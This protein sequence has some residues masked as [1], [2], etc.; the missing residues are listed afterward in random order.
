VN[1]KIS[2]VLAGIGLSTSGI[3][4]AADSVSVYGLID[5]G[6]TYYS[7]TSANK[8]M[9]RMDSGIAQSS[10][11]GFRGNEDL[12]GGNS[13]FFTLETGFSA[14]TGT[15]GQGGAIFGRQAVLGIR[16]QRLGTVSLG[17]QYDFMSNLGIAYAMGANSAA[18]SFAWG[19][20]ADAANQSILNNHIYVGDRTTNSIKYQTNDI[21]GFTG[22]LM[23]GLGEVAG[24][25]S[26]GRTVSG[27]A[28]YARGRFSTG[29]AFTHIRN[30]AD[31]GST[32]IGGFGASYVLD[33]VKV[34]GV[35]TVA[36]VT[37]TSA[38]AKTFEV[39]A[40]H[41]LTP[42][43]D[44]SG[45]W[46]YQDRNRAVSGA[47]ALVAVLDYKLSRRT[48]VYLGAVYANDNGYSA[49]PVYGGGLQ[50]AGGVQTALRVGLRHRF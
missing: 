29:A 25:A 5:L 35:A 20:H 28:S 23:Y 10:R 42:D 6:L 22:G 30:A 44:L 37:P 18:G 49:Y 24:N 16:N 26:A 7:S 12:G 40:T 47:Q 36:S 45:A 50:A 31:T 43:I 33:R 2:I 27:L 38:K 17:R 11:L 3:A 1:H 14:D 34:W 46:Q 9:I 41:A 4:Q 21:D 32:R 19:L 15:L 13:A 48:D 8:S 39:G